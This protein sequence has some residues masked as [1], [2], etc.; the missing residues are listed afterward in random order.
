MKKILFLEDRPERYQQQFRGIFYQDIKDL[1]DKI[2]FPEN[3]RK[4]FDE[5]N[6]GTFD[7]NDFNLIVLHESSL[8][9]SGKDFLKEFCD[10]NS[11]NLIK[12]S[13]AINQTSFVA[14]QNFDELSINASLLYSERLYAFLDQYN[15]DTKLLE[16]ID[17]NWPISYL[18][19]IRKL[20]NTIELESN[21]DRIMDLEDKI[22]ELKTSLNSDELNINDIDKIIKNKIYKL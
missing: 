7:C 8:N 11:I 5:I 12:F 21:E 17:D 16:L 2:F 18:M 3:P 22:E 6:D 1:G 9:T 19:L 20:Q 13:G 14:H 4:Y 15:E 10:D